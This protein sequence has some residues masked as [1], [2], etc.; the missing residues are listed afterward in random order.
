MTNVTG[1][2]GMIRGF[3]A[4]IAAPFAP[5]ATTQ[6]QA[7]LTL[8]NRTSF[9]MEAAVG[10]EKRAN[11]VTRGWYRLDPDQCRQVMDGPF[12]ADMVYLYALAD[13]KDCAAR[14]LNSAGFVVIDLVG[15]PST[16]VRF[17]EP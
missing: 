5:L 13:H 8:C 1:F 2:R 4:M 3:I 10:I 11:V 12:D 16:T 6:A 9:R 17:K 15:K 7:E 14:G